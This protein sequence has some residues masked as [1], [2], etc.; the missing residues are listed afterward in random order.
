MIKLMF[1][2]SLIKTSFASMS[3]FFLIGG[4]AVGIVRTI[5]W[6]MAGISAVLFIIRVLICL[7]TRRYKAFS[8]SW[9][10]LFGLIACGYVLLMLDI[11]IG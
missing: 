5:S 10:I 7:I 4:F 11:L 8:L 6:W 2:D 3:F 9:L 1:E